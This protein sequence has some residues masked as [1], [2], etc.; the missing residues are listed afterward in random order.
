MSEQRRKTERVSEQPQA[1]L[2][3]RAADRLSAPER[4]NIVRPANAFDSGGRVAALAPEPDIPEP[5]IPEPEAAPTNGARRASRYCEIDC[6]QLERY[7]VLTPRMA[8]SRTKEEFRVIKRS[9]LQYAF[10]RPEATAKAPNLVMVTSARPGEGKTFT[11]TN[12]AISIALERDFT[13]LLVDAD[14]TKPTILKNMG[15]EAD[16]GLIDVL[17]DPSID[18]AD[19]LIR[20]NIDKLTILPAGRSHDLS[21]ELLASQ[22][23]KNVVDD[24]AWRYRDRLVVFDAPPV[25]ATSEPCALAMHVGQI[26]FVIEAEKTPKNTVKEALELIDTGPKIGLVLNRCQSGFGYAHFG[27]YYKR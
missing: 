25:L 23:M 3:E 4:E 1:P 16:R 13:V 18:L 9:V 21:T 2:I 26:L 12:L 10:Q 19:V 14:F 22:R 17:E 5:G 7:G 8:K 24:I 15:I 20:T 27:S 11:A 6:A